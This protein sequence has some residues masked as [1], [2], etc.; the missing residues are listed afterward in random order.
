MPRPDAFGYGDGVGG[1]LVLGFI[2]YGQSREIATL[3]ERLD[4][5]SARTLQH[6]RRLKLHEEAINYNTEEGTH[7]YAR[8]HNNRMSDGK[9]FYFNRFVPWH[10]EKS[11]IE[12]AQRRG[13]KVWRYYPD[14]G[15]VLQPSG[16]F[17]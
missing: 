14:A 15:N 9:E 10:R 8:G 13:F 11:E 7:V 2:A 3:N 4:L 5:D 6:E 16:S 1:V 17:S 12:D